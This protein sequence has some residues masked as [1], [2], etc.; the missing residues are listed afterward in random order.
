[1]SQL[2]KNFPE[3]REPGI[4]YDIQ[5]MHDFFM[6]HYNNSNQ[7]DD[8]LKQ[9]NLR[10]RE[11]NLKKMKIEGGNLTAEARLEKVKSLGNL[12]ALKKKDYEKPN[13]KK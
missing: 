7:Y 12:R 5:E 2:K 4:N 11:K 1:M 10:Q 9:L 3:E 13:P 6:K 8:Q